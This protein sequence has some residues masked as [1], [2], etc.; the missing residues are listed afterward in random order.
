MGQEIERKFLVCG[1]YKSLAYSKSRIIQG[2]ICSGKGRT[3]RIRIRDNRGFITIKGPSNKTGTSRYEWEK[4]ISLQEAEELMN[5]C[6]IGRID[7]T[8]YLIKSGE[9]VFEVDE[10][11]GKNK[12]LVLA[13]IEL[14]YE[15]EPFDKPAFI[16]AEVTGEACYYNSHL[17]KMPYSKWKK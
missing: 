11:H 7:K 5:L 12:G 3:V 16:G 10:F 9:H 1:E 8:R 14:K 17:R 15:E 6:R 13:E 4:E 2:Y